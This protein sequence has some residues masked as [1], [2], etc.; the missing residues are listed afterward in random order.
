MD[1]FPKKII[2]YVS[3]FTIFSG[4][5]SYSI[6]YFAE[7]RVLYIIL[8]ALLIIFSFSLKNLCVNKKIL[9]S[10]LLLIIISSFDVLIG[11][12]TALLLIKQTVGILLNLIVFYLLLK[13][14]NYDVLKL[15]KIYL[16][17]AFITALIGIFQE[18]GYLLKLKPMYDFSYISSVWVLSFAFDSGFIRI[19]SFLPEPSIFC[20][21]M[22][23][24]FFAS[25]APF[26][27]NSIKFYNKFQSLV[28]ILSIF[29]SFSL[30]GYLGMVFTIFLLSVHWHKTT[31][32]ALKFFLIV[33]FLCVFFYKNVPEIKLRVDDII[34]ILES[35]EK[36]G[37]SNLSTFTLYSNTL[38]TLNNFRQH[39]F[40][41]TGLGSYEINYDKYI[42]KIIG[43]TEGAVYV[44]NGK[45]A[46]S[47]FLRLLSETGL[48]GVLLF[49]TFI[50]KFY[51]SSS[52]DRSNYLWVI[53]N[54]SAIVFFLKLIRSGHYFLDGFFLF[55]WLYYFSKVKSR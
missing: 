42:S 24:A 33:P 5:L 31:K 50:F 34:N 11:N 48:L 9:F 49:F 17:I 40:L 54:S 46:N 41:G 15:F 28:V 55:F 12:N 43:K 44:L 35:N 8:L 30:V 6:G 18:T 21:V 3:V 27:G 38:V 10:I 2:N 29:L 4:V 51:L 25:L 45:D 39:P 14:N 1:T 32:T 26:F 53:N 19:T 22:M 47:L 16:N 7:F 20:I 36:L 13:V 52:K 23:P 37:K